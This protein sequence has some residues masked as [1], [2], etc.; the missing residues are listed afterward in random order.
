M[1][2]HGTKVKQRREGPTKQRQVNLR[3]SRSIDALAL[4]VITETTKLQERR[5]IE[6]K[7]KR[8]PRWRGLVSTI[9]TLRKVTQAHI[10]AAAEQQPLVSQA[11]ADHAFAKRVDTST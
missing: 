4:P 11:S 10:A 3:R 8:P 1:N 2:D 7:S 6:G 5:A 9:C